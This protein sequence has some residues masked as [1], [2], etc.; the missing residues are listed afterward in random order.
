[1]KTR[2]VAI[3]L[4][5]IAVAGVSQSSADSAQTQQARA[6]ISPWVLSQ[7][8]GGK[9]TEFFIVLEDQADLSGAY[10]LSTKEEKG[11]FVFDTL[12]AKAKET[13]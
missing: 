6:K 4:L 13:Q 3:L 9:Q 10:R 5:A 12:S 1:M 2:L 7:T 8:A 11:R